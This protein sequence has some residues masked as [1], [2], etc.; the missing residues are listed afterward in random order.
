M[1][2]ALDSRWTH[3]LP[4]RGPRRVQACAAVKRLPYVHLRLISL[5]W[6]RTLRIGTSLACNENTATRRMRT[7][8]HCTGTHPVALRPGPG[9]SG[10]VPACVSLHIQTADLLVLCAE[11]CMPTCE[12][13]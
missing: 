10:D 9:L 4:A 3:H 8:L 12:V 1:R 11:H 13:A 5:T 7:L 6:Q 2:C